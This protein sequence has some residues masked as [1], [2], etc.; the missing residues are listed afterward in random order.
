M[1]SLFSFSAAHGDEPFIPVPGQVKG[2]LSSAVSAV[3]I[4]TATQ[5]ATSICNIHCPATSKQVVVMGI[6]FQAVAAAQGE[7]YY[8]CDHN[9]SVL[10]A[11]PALERLLQKANEVGLS[12]LATEHSDS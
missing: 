10:K 8:R 1:T 5:I 6:V 12:D 3:V 2:P 7:M 4:R 11:M 9:R